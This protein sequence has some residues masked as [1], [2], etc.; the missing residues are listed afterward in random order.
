MSPTWF[1]A[2]PF[3]PAELAQNDRFYL[4]FL[5]GLLPTGAA[6]AAALPEQAEAKPAPPARD[7][8]EAFDRISRAMR[9]TI[10]LARFLAEP[11]PAARRPPGMQTTRASEEPLRRSPTPPTDRPDTEQLDDPDRLDTIDRLDDISGRTVPEL[12]SEIAHDLGLP[13]PAD[14]APAA[15]S[16]TPGRDAGY[17]NLASPSP[18][19]GNASR[20]AGIDRDD[21][22]L[23]R[24]LLRSTVR[25]PDG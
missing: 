25:R 10:L 3:T 22:A 8:A 6:L 7:I 19:T 21:V 17:A 15:G 16:V 18:P 12:I 9:R 5:H 4:S 20:S 23:A 13:A 11:P 24:S 1:P 14:A 2:E